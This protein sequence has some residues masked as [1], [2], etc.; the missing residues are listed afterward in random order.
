LICRYTGLSGRK[1]TSVTGRRMFSHQ[2]VCRDDAIELSTQ[3]TA[4]QID[5]NL[6]E[7]L[8]PML[9]PLYERFDFY[10]LPLRLVQEEVERLRAGRF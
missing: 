6:V 10:E 8:H 5:D 4:Q 3:A 1:L 7:I 9:S 2:R